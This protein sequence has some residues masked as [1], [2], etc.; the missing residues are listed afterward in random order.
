[1]LDFTSALYLGMRHGHGSLRPWEA[2]TTGRPAALRS[3]PGAEALAR[4]I[5]RLTGAEK[6]ILGTSTLHIFFDLFEVLAGQGI[7]ICIEKGAYPI[8]CWGVERMAARGVPVTTFPTHAVPVLRQQ[9]S[10]IRRAG[11]HPVVV[12]DGLSPATGRPAPLDHYLGLVRACQGWLVIDDTQALGILGEHPTPKV[13]WGHGGGG[14]AA[15]HG[16]K[17]P[18]LIAVCS[19]A[20]GFGVPIAALSGSKGMVTQYER[21]STTRMHCSAPSAAH[22]SAAG[23]ALALNRRHGAQLRR[24]LMQ[25]IE[26]FRR[27]LQDAGIAVNGGFFPVQTPA[28]APE[29][30][31]IHSELLTRGIQTVLHQAQPGYPAQLSFLITASHQPR[32]IDHAASSLIRIIQRRAVRKHPERRTHAKA[33][34]L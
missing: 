32:E 8:A 3:P 16:L 5:A 20:K 14:T 19:L 26:R 27:R 28:L 4:D 15:W 12:A 17:A 10:A 33:F 1:M 9:V 24:Q 31:V 21:L 11:L 25:G 22:V 30:D 6:A 13:H 18:E 23:Q 2:L 34:G 29:S 7:G